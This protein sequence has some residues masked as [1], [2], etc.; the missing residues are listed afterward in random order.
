MNISTD[1]NADVK[2]YFDPKLIAALLA[3]FQELGTWVDNDVRTDAP[4]QAESVMETEATIQRVHHAVERIEKELNERNFAQSC[5]ANRILDE[6]EEAF[7]ARSLA[8]K[9]ATCGYWDPPGTV[10]DYLLWIE[11]EV[12]R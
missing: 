7:G 4:Q 2:Y 12:S 8:E 9:R 10:A 3:L 6:A 11:D 5:R 1:L